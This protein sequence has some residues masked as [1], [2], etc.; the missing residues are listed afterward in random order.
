ME[1][2]TRDRCSYART[3]DELARLARIWRKSV[4]DR[5]RVETGPVRHVIPLRARSFPE[6]FFTRATRS[7]VHTRSFGRNRVAVPLGIDRPPA[8]ARRHGR[9]VQVRSHRDGVRSVHVT[10]HVRDAGGQ[11]LQSNAH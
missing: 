8:K 9:Q 4:A 2:D 6:R 11:L 5:R 3:A 10:D 1:R 7:P